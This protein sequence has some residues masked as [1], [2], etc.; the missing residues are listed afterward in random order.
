MSARIF[1]VLLSLAALAGC[2]SLPPG[3]D[4]PRT[5]STSFAPPLPTPLGSEAAAQAGAH[6]GLSGVRLFARGVDGLVMRTQMVRAAQRTLDVQYYI[7]VEDYTGKVLLDAVVDA[8][9]RGVRV[10]VLVDDLN[11]H[12]RPQTRETLAA[13]DHHDNLEIRVFNPFAYRGDI[14]AVHAIDGLLNASRVNHRMHNKLMVADNAVALVGGR[15]VAD[16]Y[17][18]VGD[19]PKRFG[20]FDLAVVGPV[21]PELSGNFDAF[22]NSALSIPLA[23]LDRVPRRRA[24]EARREVEGQCGPRPAGAC[25]AN[26]QRRAAAL[27]DERPGSDV[28]GSRACRGRPARKSREQRGRRFRLAYRE[29]ARGAAQR[30]SRRARGDL[31]LPHSGGRRT[32]GDPGLAPAWRARACAH[33]FARVHRR[34]RRAHGLSQIPRAP[35]R[36]RCRALRSQACTRPGPRPQGS[37]ERGERCAVRAACQGLRVRPQH[38]ADRVGQPRPALARAQHG[39]GD[40]RRESRARG[41]DRARFEQFSAGANSY[42][43]TSDGA[44]L[45]WRTNVDGQE[46][47]WSDEPETTPGQRLK[48]DMM[49]ILPIEPLL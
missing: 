34:A 43:V 6:P 23:A 32:R 14:G 28:L 2:A 49:S 39:I 22:W 16:D 9:Q 18:D 3:A 40:R 44:A 25:T 15:N 1:V 7:F 27:G 42:L 38:G 37:R 45:Q 35:G 47:A 41:A 19:A 11:L 8:A 26:R 21:V 31:A 5:A 33:Q 17:F 4:H 46:V 36:R 24:V 20:D 48:I 10:R 13:L 30:R 29:G 12:G